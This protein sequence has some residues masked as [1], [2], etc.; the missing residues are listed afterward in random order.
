ML[1]H[2]TTL[3]IIATGVVTQ[4]PNPTYW[5]ITVDGVTQTKTA[6]GDI[7]N[8]SG[9]WGL[10]VYKVEGDFKKGQTVTFKSNNSYTGGILIA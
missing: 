8:N 9:G 3:F 6:I 1:D 7:G 10:G 4:S 2:N 5:T